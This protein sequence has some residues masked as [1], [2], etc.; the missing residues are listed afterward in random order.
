MTVTRDI[1]KYVGVG[2]VS[3]GVGG[4]VA[5]FFTRRHYEA[6]L[7]DLEELENAHVEELEE[8]LEMAPG[9]VYE[10]PVG[11]Y[12]EE[13]REE[14]DEDTRNQY[15]TYYSHVRDYTKPDIYEL[16]EQYL[17]EREHPEEDEPEEDEEM[18]K[19]EM[20]E[21]GTI[22]QRPKREMRRE[23]YLISENEFAYGEELS[24]QDKVTITY[25]A[26]DDTLCDTD[27]SE[28][29]MSDIAGDCIY[30]AFGPG[31][32]TIYIRNERLGIDYE[33]VWDPRAYS[34]AVLGLYDGSEVNEDVRDPRKKFDRDRK[35]R[36][37]WD[38]EEEE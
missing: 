9:V 3:A 19:D 12:E 37:I 34:S 11:F 7:R 21:H 14:A 32:D 38:D 16:A 24:S 30:Q 6:I 15:Q 17:A 4:G 22:E 31:V 23:P 29:I 8:D 10:R 26:G 35:R 36:N 2:V 33:V 1:W 27:E 18:I 25:Y 13:E 28:L 5:W 20:A